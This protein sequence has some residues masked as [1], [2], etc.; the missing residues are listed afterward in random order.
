MVA[1]TGL[2]PPEPTR[3]A[4]AEGAAV[5][6]GAASASPVAVRATADNPAVTLS[7]SFL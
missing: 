1:T 5:A 6:D 4:G 3:A 7:R 2:L